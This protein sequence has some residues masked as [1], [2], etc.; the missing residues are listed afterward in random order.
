MRLRTA[1]A[2][3]FASAILLAGA[4]GTASAGEVNGNGD[5]TQGLGPRQLDLCLLRPRRWRGRRACGSGRTA[6][7]LGPDPQGESGTPSPSRESILATPAT[8][9][10]VSSP[11]AAAVDP[12]RSSRPTGR[13]LR[14]LRTHRHGGCK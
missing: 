4:A 2:T 1:A 8:V 7:E 12:N 11:E 5:P 6:A 10:R 3:V 9:T 14:C 13:E